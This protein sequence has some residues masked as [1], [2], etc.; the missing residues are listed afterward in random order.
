MRL[1]A[2][3]SILSLSLVSCAHHSKPTTVSKSA[4]VQTLDLTDPDILARSS[5]EALGEALFGEMLKRYKVLPVSEE[6]TTYTNEITK[7]VADYSNRP[8][9]HYRIIIL[10]SKTTYVFGLP[11][12]RVLISKGLLDLIKTESEYACLIGD[13]I[14]HIAKQHLIQTLMKNKDYAKQL[15]EGNIS[16]RVVQQGL[17]ELLELGYDVD[18]INEADRLAPAYAMH[19]GYD[20]NA[21]LTLLQDLDAYNKKNKLV[22][23]TDQ[24]Y[25]ML[26]HRTSMNT[27]FVKALESVDKSSFPKPKDQFTAMLKKIKPLPVKKA[28]K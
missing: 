6:F 7:N 10:D 21:L 1:F 13:E 22:G 19:A 15:P 9:V 3:I 27:V 8:S 28:K 2:A 18:F 25:D 12:G 5:E 4:D 24:S 17:F 26:S 23:R 11:G 20:T 14:A 16:A